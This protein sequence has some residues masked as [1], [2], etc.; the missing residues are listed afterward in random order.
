MN[1][2]QT[3]EKVTGVLKE[4]KKLENKIKELKDLNRSDRDAVIQYMLE[5]KKRF[6]G[7]LE[8]KIYKGTY[9]L[10]ISDELF[11]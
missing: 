4:I 7:E 11:K 10:S 6:L 5:N 2:E 3:V 1:N 9:Y 8:L